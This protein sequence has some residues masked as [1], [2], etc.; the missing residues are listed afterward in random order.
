MLDLTL[1]TERVRQEEKKGRVA[2]ARANNKVGKRDGD[3]VE[4]EFL[5][6]NAVTQR[7]GKGL[8][9]ETVVILSLVWQY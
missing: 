1:L 6:E 3:R 8:V 9:L 5:L 2:A 7:L 4:K